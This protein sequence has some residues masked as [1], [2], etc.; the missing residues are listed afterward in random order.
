MAGGE[1]YWCNST[2][3]MQGGIQ[4]LYSTPHKLRLIGMGCLLE[5]S[6]D[7]QSGL[8][9]V[10]LL[11]GP[12]EQ[13]ILG[14]RARYW[15]LLCFPCVHGK[16]RG[17]K[18]VCFLAQISGKYLRRVPRVTCEAEIFELD[19]HVPYRY[20]T[21]SNHIKPFFTFFSFLRCRRRNPTLQLVCNLSQQNYL[22]LSSY[23]RRHR[24]ASKASRYFG[25]GEL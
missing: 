13:W 20:L 12:Y 25:L 1:S 18:Q 4:L 2:R 16:K 3:M 10:Y 15:C 7:T 21:S 8:M 23:R 5:T 11:D 17:T 6:R 19:A 22:C 14:V 24:Q 9:P